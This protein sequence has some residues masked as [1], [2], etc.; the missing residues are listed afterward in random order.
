[1]SGP[2]NTVIAASTAHAASAV[3]TP[4]NNTVQVV[5]PNQIPTQLTKEH[6]RRFMFAFTR[7]CE[8]L[9]RLHRTIP[10]IFECSFSPFKIYNYSELDLTITMGKKSDGIAITVSGKNPNDNTPIE[11]LMD[12]SED[13]EAMIICAFKQEQRATLEVFAIDHGKPKVIHEFWTVGYTHGEHGFDLPT[14]IPDYPSLSETDLKIIQSTILST[15]YYSNQLGISFLCMPTNDFSES[16]KNKFFKDISVQNGQPLI[17]YS[18]DGKKYFA[19]TCGKAISKDNGE[20]IEMAFEHSGTDPQ[21][22][23]AIFKNDRVIFKMNDEEVLT[24]FKQNGKDKFCN[25]FQNLFVGLNQIEIVKSNKVKRMMKVPATPNWPGFEKE[26]LLAIFGSEDDKKIVIAGNPTATNPNSKPY[27]VAS[28]KPRYSGSFHE[29]YRLNSND[30]LNDIQFNNPI[31][32]DCEDPTLKSD[33]FNFSIPIVLIPVGPALNPYLSGFE[34]LMSIIP[35]MMSLQQIR[36]IKVNDFFI[37]ANIALIIKDYAD[38]QDD[39]PTLHF[40]KRIQTFFK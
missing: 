8:K 19:L 35:G 12:Y 1:M 5:S 10:Q 30:G 36:A 37:N 11:W 31:S 22:F 28:L 32:S 24:L 7:I 29:S 39:D 33:S 23:K 20:T 17:L 25:F 21:L 13:S 15:F 3:S 9:G 18:F 27:Q 16:F 14:D 34:E 26:R 4:A 2:L 6:E 40:I 38:S